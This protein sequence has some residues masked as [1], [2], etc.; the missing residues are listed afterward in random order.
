MVSA[1]VV[2][3]QLPAQHWDILP[4]LLWEEDGRAGVMGCFPQQRQSSES[5]CNKE[6]RDLCKK[7]MLGLCPLCSF[8]KQGINCRVLSTSRSLHSLYPG[9][10]LSQAIFT[11]NFKLVLRRKSTASG[12]TPAPYLANVL[13][14]SGANLQ[15][16]LRSPATPPNVRILALDRI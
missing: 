9:P 1:I 13:C 16:W 12:H 3:T 10:P 6:N 8:Q 11:I 7:K 5:S 4:D 14:T 15:T 2:T